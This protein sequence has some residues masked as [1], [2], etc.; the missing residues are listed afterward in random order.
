MDTMRQDEDDK[1]EEE[2]RGGEGEIISTGVPPKCGPL[3]RLRYDKEQRG[4]REAFI[5]DDGSGGGVWGR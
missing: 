2:R 1:G 4:I 3:S 5:D